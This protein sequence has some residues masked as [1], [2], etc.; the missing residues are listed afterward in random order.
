MRDTVRAGISVLLASAVLLVVLEMVSALAFYHKNRGALPPSSTVA[1]LMKL[2]GVLAPPPERPSKLQTLVEMRSREPRVYPHYLFN[3]QLHERPAFYHLGNV[4][5]S[6]IL[7][8]D[9]AGYWA[10]WISD[11]IGFRNP[12]GQL[13]GAVDYI[14]LGDSFTEGACEAEADTFAGQFRAAGQ[15][16]MNLGRGGSGPLFQ[17]A[18][19]REFGPLVRARQVVW[20]VFAGNDMANLR[21]EKTTPLIRYLEDPAYSQDLAGRRDEVSARLEHFLDRQVALDLERR[22]QGRE[23]PY[24]AQGYGETLDIIEAREKEAGLF[25]QVAAAILRQTRAQGAALRIV[26]LEHPSEGYPHDIQDSTAGAV[27]GFAEKAGVPLLHVD[28]AALAAEPDLYTPVGS[29]FG[30]EGYR[31]IAGRVQAWLTGLGAGPEK[32]PEKAPEKGQEKDRGGVRAR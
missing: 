2:T 7:F 32:A 25:G 23:L 22:E 10:S 28:R 17:L 16:V 15:R 9:E 20:F 14:L 5:R 1:A 13:G 12:A 4:A 26:L 18:T 8:C 29:H 21:E 3:P 6:R 24:A 11:E 31:R 19:L 30:A 27:R